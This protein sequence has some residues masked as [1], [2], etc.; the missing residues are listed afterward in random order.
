MRHGG[1][2]RA[3]M[4]QSQAMCLLPVSINN[5]THLC[6]FA[7]LLIHRTHLGVLGA[8]NGLK[9]VRCTRMVFIGP[10]SDHWDCLSLTH[11]SDSLIGSLTDSCL[12]NMIDVTMACED[13]NS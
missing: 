7:K 8:R 11:Y 4:G 3:L 13:D 1:P 2:T 6:V 10:E 5:L 9:I 12:V